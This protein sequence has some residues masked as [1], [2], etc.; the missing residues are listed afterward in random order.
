LNGSAKSVWA[1]TDASGTYSIPVPY[2]DYR[3]DG[4]ELDQATADRL[5]AGK[6]DSPANSDFRRR[7]EVVEA[8]PGVSLTLEYVNPVI[9]LGPKGNVALGDDVAITWAPYPNAA[10]YRIQI[11]E[12]E[13]STG[14][15]GGRG[16]FPWNDRPTVQGTVLNLREA[17]MEPKSGHYYRVEIDALDE[18]R[19]A[20]STNPTR[21]GEALFWVGR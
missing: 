12:S 9:V 7:F 4:Y 8:Q 5:L 6:I 14:Y 2:G 10:S 3:I 1:D 16:L 21:F 18:D 17:G 13:S 19:V 20:I 15:I 11:Y